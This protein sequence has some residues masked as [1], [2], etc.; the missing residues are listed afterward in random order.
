LTNKYDAFAERITEEELEDGL[1][2]DLSA[3]ELNLGELELDRDKVRRIKRNSRMVSVLLDKDSMVSYEHPPRTRHEV[4]GGYKR[5]TKRGARLRECE[6]YNVNFRF[7]SWL[8]GTGIAL[9]CR[10]PGT[11]EEWILLLPDDTESRIVNERKAYLKEAKEF[12]AVGSMDPD[13]ESR[14]IENLRLLDIHERCAQSLMHEYGHALHYRMFDFLRF[15]E[16]SEHYRWFFETGYLRNVDLRYPGFGHL[17]AE[18]KLT[19]LK[20]A[21]VE[22]YRISLNMLSESGKFI[23][24]NKVC[25]AGDFIKPKLMYEGV[26]IM[27]EM[28][29]P[30]IQGTRQTTY[31]SE[32]LDTLSYVKKVR[33][34]RKEYS[35]TPGNPSMTEM[36][37]MNDLQE[38]KMNEARSQIASARE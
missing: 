11:K 18:D 7:K 30:I 17:T 15:S 6:V 8:I 24:P 14:L 9:M 16:K 5:A 10:P 28:L 25:Y 22:D 21:L 13:E 33:A 38:L 19:E 29:K 27:K 12:I 1:D 37:V 23:L 2:I 34:R 20:E 26:E 36:D 35:W 3:V 32:D 4:L 31:S